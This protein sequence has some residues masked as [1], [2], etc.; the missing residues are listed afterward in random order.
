MEISNIDELATLRR[1]KL[2][3]LCKEQRVSVSLQ[4]CAMR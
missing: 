2:Q 3:K 4:R 1:P